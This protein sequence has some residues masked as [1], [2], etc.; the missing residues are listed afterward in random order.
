VRAGR[1]SIAVDVVGRDAEVALG[2]HGELRSIT[3]G[4]PSPCIPSIGRPILS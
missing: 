1:R 4:D 2:D 3:A